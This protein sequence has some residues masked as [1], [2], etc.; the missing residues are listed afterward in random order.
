MKNINKNQQK[1]NEKEGRI[2]KKNFLN[3]RGKQSKFLNKQEYLKNSNNQMKI[4]STDLSMNHEEKI[5]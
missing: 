1:I 5:D 2:K 3:I 4:G